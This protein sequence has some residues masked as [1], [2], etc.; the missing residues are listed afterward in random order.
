MTNLENIL[1]KILEKL[2]KII[3]LQ[4]KSLN[5]NFH[6]ETLDKIDS[7]SSEYDFPTPWN[8]NQITCENDILYK[9][10][11]KPTWYNIKDN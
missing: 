10:P 3:S 11:E 1:T 5:P 7:I 2:D 4:E 8:D 6:L 9:K